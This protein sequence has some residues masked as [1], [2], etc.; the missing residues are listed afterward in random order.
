MKARS[1]KKKEHRRRGVEAPEPVLIEASF[2]Q[3]EYAYSL[4]E[5]AIL[6]QQELNGIA[7]ELEGFV[8]E[9]RCE[10]IISMLLENQRNNILCGFNYGQT[11]ILRHLKKFC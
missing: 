8:S 11:D 2:S 7:Y 3:I 6:S 9:G 4:M 10:E 5:T 1:S